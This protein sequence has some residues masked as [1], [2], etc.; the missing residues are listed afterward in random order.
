MRLT[1]F[2]RIFGSAK[3]FGKSSLSVC[4][5]VNAR[6]WPAKA[7]TTPDSGARQLVRHGPMTQPS[8]DE[9]VADCASDVYYVY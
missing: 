2:V 4:C 3:K 7:K 5:R 6:F 9:P 1:F 8:P